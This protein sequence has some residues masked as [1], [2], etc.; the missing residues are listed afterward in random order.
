MDSRFCKANFKLRTKSIRFRRAASSN[1]KSFG[2]MAM[3]VLCCLLSFRRSIVCNAN[4]ASIKSSM[5][6]RTVWV[7]DCF[8]FGPLARA[9]ASVCAC[10]HRC[11]FFSSR[12]RPRYPVFI[13]YHGHNS[14]RI[15]F[16][17]KRDNNNNKKIYIDRGS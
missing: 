15:V 7:A 13:D 5:G 12:F 9:R 10:T 2:F 14:K 8:D 1:F 11:D 17:F 4:N 3:I 16:Y 6:G